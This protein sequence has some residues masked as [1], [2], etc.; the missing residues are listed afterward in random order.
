[1]AF[2][3]YV[4][5]A[6]GDYSG[7]ALMSLFFDMSLPDSVFWG[8]AAIKAASADYDAS[9][10]YITEMDRPGSI[11]G[12]PASKTYAPIK[13]GGLEIALIDEVYRKPQHTGVETLM[14][15]GN[16]DFST[17][18]QFARDELL[19]VMPRAELVVLSEMGHC[20]DVEL[21]QKDAFRHLAET[22]LLSGVVDDSKFVPQ[23]MDFEPDQRLSDMAHRYLTY[24]VLALVVFVALI[25]AVVWFIRRRRR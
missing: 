25:C 9:R 21:L 12:S 3:A 19:P 4:S 14:V 17:P 10:D 7:L 11:L 8:D 20:G 1:M 18:P 15:N 24:A 13:Y 16:I 6:E 23:P 22:F 5:A 2:D